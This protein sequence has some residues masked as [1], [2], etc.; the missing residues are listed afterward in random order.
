M[1]KAPTDIA[2]A[3]QEIESKFGPESIVSLD[4]IADKDI[5]SIRTGSMLL[6][7]ALGVGGFPIGRMVEL[8]GA[9]SSG[10]STLA[11]ESAKACQND[12]GKAVLYLDFEHAFDPSYVGGVIGVDLSPNKFILSQPDTL[13]EGLSIAD[14]MI[15]HDM[16]GMVIVDSVASMVSEKERSGELEESPPMVTARIMSTILR[17]LVG[18]LKAS[19]ACMIFINHVRDVISTGKSW[20]PPKRTTPGGRALKFYA[21]VRVELGAVAS[22][23]GKVQDPITGKSEEGS[24]G[25][26][27]RATVVKNKVG[28]P[29]QKA[30]FYMG[31][32]KGVD[33]RRTLIEVATSRGIMSQNKSRFVFPFESPTDP[34]KKV[35]V[36]GWANALG[37]LDDNPDKE[38][39]LRERVLTA[40]AEGEPY[41]DNVEFADESKQ[42]PAL[43]G[44]S[45]DSL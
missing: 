37:W 44:L 3:R 36:G 39:Q 17:K 20:G 24:V 13:E 38:E 27:V 14:Y 15:R 5:E 41:Q 25:V 28:V 19:G 9:E 11:F 10:K 7:S 33:E 6:D 2:S 29:F 22:V 35:N 34:A 40:L 31:Q 26:K 45:G 18:P 21:S 23:K 16:V 43:V 1:S 32:G 12:L 30:F 42:G 4:G 8:F